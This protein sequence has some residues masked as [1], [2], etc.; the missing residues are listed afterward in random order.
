MI[1]LKPEYLAATNVNA[2]I[3]VLSVTAMI[4]FSQMMVI[5]SGGIN[6]S[7]G[8]TG[9]L[10]AIMAGGIMEKMGAPAGLALLAGLLTG[11]L[12]GAINGLLIYRA[13]GVGVAFFLTTLATASVFQGINL[14]ITSG[15]PYY[16]I[17]PMF[18]AF[19]DTKFFGLQLSFYYVLLIAI[20]TAISPL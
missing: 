11:M 5:A 10:S 2:L 20:L 8:A 7:I 15:T 12:C 19:G 18:Y 9:A 17:D 13:G 14:M 16:D 4:G 6:V 3:K 1:S